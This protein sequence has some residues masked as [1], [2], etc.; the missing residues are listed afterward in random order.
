VSPSLPD[1][2]DVAD[3][4]PPGRALVSQRRADEPV[5]QHQLP[6]GQRRADAL[7]AELRPA[8]HEQQHLADRVHR[9]AVVVLL[10][11]QQQ[12]ANLLADVRPARL[13]HLADRDPLGLRRIDQPMKLR[14]LARPIRPIKHDEPA[15]EGCEPGVIRVSHAQSIVNCLIGKVLIAENAEAR[16]RREIAGS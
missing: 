3:R 2:Q 10:D 8:G 9:L 11:L 13:T 16:R 6:A 4:D 14:R 12:V 5:G 15:G 7:G 1:A